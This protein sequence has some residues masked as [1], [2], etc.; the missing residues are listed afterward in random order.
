MS[1]MNPWSTWT[2]GEKI[3]FR[4]LLMLWSGIFTRPT[5]QVNQTGSDWFNGEPHRA[6]PVSVVI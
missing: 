1:W 5:L 6:E 4:A 2:G 3:K